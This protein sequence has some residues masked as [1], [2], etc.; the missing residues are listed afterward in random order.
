MMGRYSSTNE[1]SKSSGMAPGKTN[2]LFPDPTP[3]KITQARAPAARSTSSMVRFFSRFGEL[4]LASAFEE[5]VARPF[6]AWFFFFCFAD[7]DFDFRPSK[8]AHMQHS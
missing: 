4:S 8:I 6:W 3:T 1:F 7:F 2:Q 5:S